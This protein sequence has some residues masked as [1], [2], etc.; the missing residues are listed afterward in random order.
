M[1]Q[2]PHQAPRGRAAWNIRK[3]DNCSGSAG[4]GAYGV[5]FGDPLI[6]AVAACRR[7]AYKSGRAAMGRQLKRA[8]IDS[9]QS[10]EFK[11]LQSACSART[12]L[13][14]M[15]APTVVNRKFPLFSYS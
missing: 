13:S 6:A 8:F 11:A 4:D 10:A 14:L 7:E 12:L 15:E 5:D 3:T 1:I 9:L 2:R